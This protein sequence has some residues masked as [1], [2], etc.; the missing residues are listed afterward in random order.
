MKTIIKAPAKINLLLK[1][2][3]KLDDS[4]RDLTMIV[5]SISLFDNIEIEIVKNKKQFINLLN[6]K[7]I[8]IKYSERIVLISN[9]SYIPTDDK[10][11]IVKVI[12]YFIEKYN[13]SD[14]FYIKLKKNIPTGAGLGGG[15]SDA[16]SVI[17]FLNKYYKLNLSIDIMVNIALKF[18]ADIPF[19]IYKNI[20]LCEGKGEKIKKL[21]NFNKYYVL[22]ATPN[23]NV[24]TKEIFNKYNELNIDNSNENIIKKQKIDNALLAIKNKNLFEFTKNLYNDLEVITSIKIKEINIFKD[25]MIKNGAIFSMMSGSGGTV[26]GIFNSSI[27]AYHCKKKI[28]ENYKNAFVYVAKPI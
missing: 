3:H 28:K 8:Y 9:L 5:Q 22:I 20:C 15:S 24:S 12:K 27:K 7:N 21:N 17:L 26:F 6:K 16:G 2:N 1:V 4:Y 14:Y 11:L 10:N 13:I 23:I 25:L 19:F 18:G